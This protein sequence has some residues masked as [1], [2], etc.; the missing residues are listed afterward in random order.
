MREYKINN[1]E[2]AMTVLNQAK[3]CNR[4]FEISG[5]YDIDDE[6]YSSYIQERYIFCLSYFFL[7]KMLINNENTSKA[8]IFEF[9]IWDYIA[10]RISMKK[11]IKCL[12]SEN[13][14]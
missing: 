9:T 2:E 13:L 10:G 3:E 14:I 11:L 5:A 6:H 1:F 4:Q 12:K 7:G 8:M